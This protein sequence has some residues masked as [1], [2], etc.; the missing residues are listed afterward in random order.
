[1]RSLGD[2]PNA[3]CLAL[4]GLRKTPL[5]FMGRWTELVEHTGMHALRSRIARLR[6]QHLK[7]L[8]GRIPNSGALHALVRRPA[9]HHRH[10]GAHPTATALMSGPK[11]PR[12][13]GAV[14]AVA[15]ACRSRRSLNVLVMRRLAGPV[16]SSGPQHFG[17][18]PLRARS[19]SSLTF[20]LCGG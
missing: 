6:L 11:R 20:L 2:V 9:E 5:A 15:A 3:R 17:P 8:V 10:E 12:F 4:S 16:R 18:S 7:T 19:R 13:Q 14:S 1:M